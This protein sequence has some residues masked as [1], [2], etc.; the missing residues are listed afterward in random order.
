[1]NGIHLRRYTSFPIL[2][3]MLVNRRITLINPASWEDRNDSFYVE[4]YREIKKLRTLL[5]LCFTTKP[6]TFHHWKVFAGNSGGICVRF[7]TEKLVA[8]FKQVPGIR[9]GTVIYRRMRDLKHNPPSVNELLFLKRKQYE[10]ETE[11]RI[12]YENKNKTLQTKDLQLDLQCIE[13]ITLSPWLPRSVSKTIKGVIRQI[14]GCAS[15][16]L[17]RTGIVESLVWQNMIN[18]LA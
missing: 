8:C 5:A 14:P 16:P 13:K 12:I 1:M 4:K 10:D 3:D 7:N 2:L 11:F 18:K 9:T 6:E 15:M 17:I